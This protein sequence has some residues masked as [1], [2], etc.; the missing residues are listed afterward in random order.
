MGLNKKEAAR[1]LGVSYSAYRN[2]ERGRAEPGV[3][4]DAVIRH[5]KA[6]DELSSGRRQ[7]DDTG[8]PIYDSP[9]SAGDGSLEVRED[10]IGYMPPS[11]SLSSAGR[12]V[13]WVPVRGDSMG[14]R[15][16]MHTLVPVSRFDETIQDIEEDGVYHIRLENAVMIKRLQ[17]RPGG[18]IRIVSDN[19]AYEDYDIALDEGLDFEVLGRVLV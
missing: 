3:G 11:Q 12:D 2:W 9:A 19:D 13:Y 10:P 18:R 17:R 16:Q 5:L 15:Y 7:G 4:F 8:D 14:E 1:Q 6:G